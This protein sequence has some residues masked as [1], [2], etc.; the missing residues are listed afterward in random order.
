MYG[1]KEKAKWMRGECDE[2]V[3]RRRKG[4]SVEKE[5]GGEERQCRRVEG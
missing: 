5:E 3:Q 4:V 1:V 2:N